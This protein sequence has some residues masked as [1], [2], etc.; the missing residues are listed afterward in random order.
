MERS[1]TG[2]Q[3]TI[4]QFRP[5]GI[6][7]P[8]SGSSTVTFTTEATSSLL[9]H[10]ATCTAWTRLSGSGVVIAVA[11]DQQLSVYFDSSLAAAT[12]TSATGDS[13]SAA[14]I[15]EDAQAYITTVSLDGLSGCITSIALEGL[16]TD[17]DAAIGVLG[18]T[19]GKIVPFVIV[20][21]GNRI[22]NSAVASN[23]A[24]G[25]GLVKPLVAVLPALDLSAATSH[26][27]SQDEPVVSVAIG[28]D[29]TRRVEFVAAATS[30]CAALFSC[31]TLFSPTSTE[32]LLSA[33]FNAHTPEDNDNSESGAAPQRRRAFLNQLPNM[34]TYKG[35][36]VYQSAAILRISAF[37]SVVGFGSNALR[38]VFPDGNTSSVVEDSSPLDRLR[39]PVALT[40]GGSASAVTA[41]M[42][43]GSLEIV[44]SAV[45]AVILEDGSLR[46]I[47]R[48]V[49]ARTWGGFGRNGARQ[50][51]VSASMAPSRSA[52]GFPGRQSIT[53]GQ[54]TGLTLARSANLYSVP[55]AVKDP[56]Y[57]YISLNDVVQ[58]KQP[59]QAT[60]PSN[61]ANGAVPLSA[62]K[63]LTLGSGAQW[64]A[65]ISAA[66][67]GQTENRL[68][69]AELFYNPTTGLVDTVAVGA[70]VSR[71]NHQNASASEFSGEYAAVTNKAPP[72]S[73]GYLTVARSVAHGSVF[74]PSSTHA[75]VVDVDVILPTAK[76]GVATA[77]TH[78][79]KVGHATSSHRGLSIVRV[80][81]PPPRPSTCPQACIVAAGNE[82]FFNVATARSG[83]DGLNSTQVSISSPG[84]IASSAARS[85]SSTTAPL[86]HLCSFGGPIQDITVISVVPA[87][88]SS[89][90][91]QQRYTATLVVALGRR[92]H[93]VKCTF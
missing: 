51:P 39:S 35:F 49:D 38:R 89:T 84:A 59:A 93:L 79:H 15:G 50:M 74:H 60:M 16:S 43:G 46:F 92:V 33:L 68:N 37:S 88:Q 80:L 42:K 3:R 85:P 86:V 4:E 13:F 34:F 40:Y 24:Y 8:T 17:R 66:A 61:A 20:G 77:A 71:A 47:G 76:E 87:L 22:Y 12:Q 45:L 21:P 44:A 70:D 56:E 25:R 62:T 67:A 2:Q 19:T 57:Q 58:I 18:L 81:S 78:F 23:P 72:R 1:F 48:C 36:N 41:T 63:H 7:S 55:L 64:A 75:M 9:S 54:D 29:S 91:T 52:S 6:A 73:L 28:L 14:T 30:N 27:V 26:S 31:T 10:S 11:G 65:M 82:L 69:D 5:I 53:A 90:S 83:N 32:E